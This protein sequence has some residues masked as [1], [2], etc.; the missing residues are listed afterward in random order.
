MLVTTLGL[1]AGGN[2]A[3]A[4]SPDTAPP[5]L[6]NALTQIDAAANRRNVQAVMQF[7]SPNF[8]HS[9]GLNRQNMEKALTQLW[10]RYPKL[11]YR[12]Q[13]QSWERDRTGAIV[14]ETVTQITGTQPVDGRDW[15]FNATIRSRQRFENQKVVRQ[16]ILSERTQ[17]T[18]GEKPPTVD[19]KLPDKVR[20][21]Q[22]FNFDAIVKEPLGDDVLVGA[23]LEEPISTQGYLNP[24][25]VPLEP[26]S[27][28]GIFK[29]GRAPKAGKYWI[30]AVL[31]RADGMTI[32]TQRL[33]VEG[34]S[35]PSRPQTRPSTPQTRPSGSPN[36]SSGSS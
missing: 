33:Q 23:A 19:L 14:A 7:Y 13:L 36:R 6:K 29:Q 25:Q 31:V 8:T 30:S 28:G 24:T 9:D 10:Q 21:G 32:V 4:A 22:E 26:L 12:T 18:S 3:F 17:M 2:L 11:N 27:A 1:S 20:A 15:N 5:E 35:N 34:N 16:E